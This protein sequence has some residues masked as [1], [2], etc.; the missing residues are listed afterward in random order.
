MKPFTIALIAVT[1]ATPVA[2]SDVEETRTTLR[3]HVLKL[4][5]RDRA[6]YNLPPVELDVAASAIGDAY[7][8]EQ[9][10][11]G[12]TGH[13]GVDGRPPY[14]RY[15]L[16][17]GNDGVS[18]NAAA[19]SANYTFSDR[20]LYEMSRRSQDAMM[21]EAPPKDGHRRTILDPH[22]THVGIGLAW[23]RGEF[24]L[25]HEF[26]RRYVDWTRPLPRQ[27]RLGDE[28]I[29]RGRPLRGTSV[30][31]ITV[32]YEPVPLAMPA[33][34]ASAFESYAL[35]DKRKEYR[36]R[37]RQSVRQRLDGTLEISRR[38]Y[39]DGRRGDFYLGD[40]GAFSFTV[41]FPEGAGIY[42]VVVWV[43]KEGATHAVAASNVSIRVD[44]A[45]QTTT[46]ASAAGR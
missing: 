4:I 7:C 34:V 30:E 15:S 38:E 24:R 27:A 3:Q 22:A 2:H 40:D 35:P 25:V 36:P 46:R 16:A 18:E 6:I 29:A 39:P 9:I 11:T 1:L 33:H 44:S 41:P 17:G 19:W 20:A 26:I 5:N 8:R 13:F 14:M 28:V 10:R 43:R 23:E 21:A 31:A 37:L 42:T 45:L 32:H 12:S